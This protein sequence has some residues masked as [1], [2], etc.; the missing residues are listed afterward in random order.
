MRRARSGEEVQRNGRQRGRA[1]RAEKS[2]F[3]ALPYKNIRKYGG[4]VKYMFKT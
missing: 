2:R 3:L 4:S 1:K